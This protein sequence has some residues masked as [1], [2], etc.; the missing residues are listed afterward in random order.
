[1]RVVFDTNVLVSAFI[2]QGVCSD[3]LE[4]CARRHRVVASEFLLDEFRECL[5]RKFHFDVREAAEAAELVKSAAEIVVPEPSAVQVCRDRDDDMVLGTA[6][7][8]NAACIVTGDMD[9][10]VLR[11]YRGIVILRPSEFVEFEA[12]GKADREQKT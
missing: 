11:E 2:A 1:M 7:A 10:L 8:G 5:I 4:H 3:L 9:L 12:G 6:M